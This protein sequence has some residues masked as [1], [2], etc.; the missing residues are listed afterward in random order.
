METTWNEKQ[1]KAYL[2]L[3]CANIDNQ[4]DK[5][6]LTIIKSQIDEDAYK[7]IHDEFDNDNDYQ[8]VEKISH[9][10]DRLGYTKKNIDQLV[11]EMKALFMAD[12]EFDA[13]EQALFI[14]LK[15]LLN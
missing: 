5:N 14:G 1:L 6:E 2:L 9:A 11:T 8:S 13:T 3:Y 12:G 15:R 7:K 4:E 10:L